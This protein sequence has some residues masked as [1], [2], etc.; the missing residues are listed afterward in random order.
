[1]DGCCRLHA[2]MHAQTAATT[3][4]LI[5]PRTTDESTMMSTAGRMLLDICLITTWLLCNRNAI[6]VYIGKIVLLPRV[7]C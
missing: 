2:L 7:C 5:S 6:Y 1:M 4:L 3:L